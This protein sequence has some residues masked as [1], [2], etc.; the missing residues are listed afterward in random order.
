LPFTVEW[1]GP[2]V[3]DMPKWQSQ[4]IKLSPVEI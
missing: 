3:G 4:K 1:T 2:S